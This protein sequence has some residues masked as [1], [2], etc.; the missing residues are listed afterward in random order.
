MIQIVKILGQIYK[1]DEPKLLIWYGWNIKS[2]NSSSETD[3]KGSARGVAL[4]WSCWDKST[5][6]RYYKEMLHLHNKKIFVEQTLV[7]REHTKPI[8]VKFYVVCWN[9]RGFVY[10]SV[11]KQQVCNAS[12][13]GSTYRLYF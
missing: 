1:A 8:T 10:S 5:C 12:G 4:R 13:V 2:E 7:Y 6:Y 11:N 9:K 3:V